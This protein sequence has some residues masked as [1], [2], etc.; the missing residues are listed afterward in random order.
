MDDQEFLMILNMPE[1]LNFEKS[2]AKR[3][4]IYDL[5]FSTIFSIFFYYF[6]GIC[7]IILCLAVFLYECTE[8]D[9]SL[10]LILGTGF[11]MS[12]MSIGAW[13]LGRLQKI[14]GGNSDQ[15]RERIIDVLKTRYPRIIIY[16]F[17]KMIIA[18]KIVPVMA[19]DTTIYIIPDGADLY[20]NAFTIGR[21]DIKYLFLSIP[22]YIRCKKI[23]REFAQM[24]G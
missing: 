13:L 21:G 11:L 7:L 12:Y 16:S 8:N 1:R 10:L 6:F 4:L 3:R 19:F 22:N 24:I 18:K 14:E 23:A 5:N 15:N 20:I 2:V 9:P 17:P